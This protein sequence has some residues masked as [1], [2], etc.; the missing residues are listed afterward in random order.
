[1]EA[2]RI[3]TTADYILNV[4]KASGC[5]FYSWGFHSPK[6]VIYNNMP[7]LQFTVDGFI[8]KGD[9]VVAYNGCADLFELYLLNKLE[10]VKS[11]KR[12]YVDEL[13]RVIDSLVEKNCSDEKYKIEVINEYSILK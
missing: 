12:I 4:I 13:V 8:H 6:T 1:M 9:V 5:I 3:N 7:A 10:V 2:E 11:M